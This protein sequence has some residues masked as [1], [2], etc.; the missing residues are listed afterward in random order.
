MMI[1]MMLF[2]KVTIMMMTITTRMLT[3]AVLK[4]S[5]VSSI[6]FIIGNMITTLGLKCTNSITKDVYTHTQIYIYICTKVIVCYR[7]HCFQ[8]RLCCCSCC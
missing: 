7:Y 4:M 6:L 5:M 3:M 8:C 2:S 1:A